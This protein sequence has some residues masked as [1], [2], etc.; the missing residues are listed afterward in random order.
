[1]NKIITCEECGI[2]Y[3]GE[4]IVPRQSFRHVFPDI[5]KLEAELADKDR[6]L[7]DARAEIE[8]LKKIAAH[9][10][11]VMLAVADSLDNNKLTDEDYYEDGL[12]DELRSNAEEK[13][14]LSA[15]ERTKL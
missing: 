6:Q 4:T 9:R 12:I 3:Y 5:V 14:A 2:D 11:D 1:M 13:A 7:K 8:R 15:A 10:R